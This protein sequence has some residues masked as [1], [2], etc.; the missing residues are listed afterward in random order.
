[1][2]GFKNGWRGELEKLARPGLSTVERLW[3]VFD[4][5]FELFMCIT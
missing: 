4:S 2:F 3:N 1:M 5:D